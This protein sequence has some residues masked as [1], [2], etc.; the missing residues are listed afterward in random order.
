MKFRSLIA[1]LIITASASSASAHFQVIMPGNDIVSDISKPLPLKLLF[2]H[3]MDWGPVMEMQTPKQFGV[4]AD[5]R[6]KDLLGSLK[7]MKIDGKSAYSCEFSGQKEPGDCV[8]YVEP[9]PYWEPAERK[10]ITHYAKVVVDF[11]GSGEG[12]DALVGFPV[13][14]QPLSRPYGLYEGNIFQGVVLKNGK[15]APFANVEIEFYNEGRKVEAA[16]DMHAT[17]VVKADANGVFSYAI[18]RA[19][20]WGFAA[21]VDGEKTKGPDGKEAS[22]ELGGLIWVKAYT[23]K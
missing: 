7:L 15:P 4:L 3:P 22:A 19:G 11:L 12:W 6:K 18:P 23:W 20:W 8:F 2:T 1:S 9:A 21:L 5:G 14:I 10:Y 16:T 17:Q 13:E